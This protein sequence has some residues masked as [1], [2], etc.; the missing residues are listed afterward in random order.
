MDTNLVLRDGSANLTATE[1]LTAVTIGPMTRPLWLHIVAPAGT[2]TSPT[3]D[4]KLSFCTAAAPTTEVYSESMKQIIAA[5]H[6]AVPFYTKEESLKVTL[7]V[8]GTT[9]NFGGVK[10]W[11]DPA[12]RYANAV[13]S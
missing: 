1:V 12:N 8:G 2:G 4:A 13:G 11:I 3:L 9:P 10:V 6:Y 7:T 5:G